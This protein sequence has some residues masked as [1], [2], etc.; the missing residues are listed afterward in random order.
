MSDP[1]D[2]VTRL[3][4][5]TKLDLTPDLVMDAARGHGMREVVVIGLDPDGA[6]YFAGSSADGPLT[7]WLLEKARRALLDAAL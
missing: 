6:F 4:V 5:E 2:N 7:L 3:S 1:H